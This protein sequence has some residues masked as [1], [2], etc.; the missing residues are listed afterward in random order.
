LRWHGSVFKN[1]II[2]TSMTTALSVIAYVLHR[3]FG[4]DTWSPIGH[5][6]AGTL[7]AFLVVFRSQ[8]AWNMY[9][10]GR[11]HVGAIS[12]KARCLCTEMFGSIAAAQ[13]QMPPEA[14]KVVRLIKLFYFTAVENV[15]ANE[16][17]QAYRFSQSIAYGHATVAEVQFLLAEFGTWDSGLSKKTSMSEIGRAKVPVLSRAS[18]LVEG[19]W[20]G[21]AAAPPPQSITAGA[22]LEDWA[23]RGCERA[24]EAASINS[25]AKAPSSADAGDAAYPR[26][27]PHDSTVSKPLVVMVWITKCLKRLVA[28]GIGN[29]RHLSEQV[30]GL[31]TAYNG[32]CK[33]DDVVLPLPYC[34]LLKTILMFWNFTLP[35]VI[36]K[37]TELAVIPT[38]FVTALAFFGLD[39]VGAEL[40][41]PFG[42]DTNDFPLL[43]MG[44]ALANDMDSMLWAAKFDA[45]TTDAVEDGRDD[46]GT[47]VKT[48][49]DQTRLTA[50]PVQLQDQEAITPPPV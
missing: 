22:I 36:V 14:E 8:I 28:Q 3:D 17:E 15:R 48:A 45:T 21:K 18:D 4:I 26:R 11:S 25:S 16:G 24:V 43:K 32:M 12:G 38:C 34:Q 9:F 49:D 27:L 39:Q 40:E 33:I 41:G 29:E 13:I 50:L 35:F 1:V 30:E 7:L 47:E 37:E 19:A 5:Q 42:V 10:E 20:N 44:L 2:E 23:K 6:L 31:I 46:G